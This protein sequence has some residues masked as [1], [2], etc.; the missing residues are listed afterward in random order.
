MFLDYE[1]ILRNKYIYTMRSKDTKIYYLMQ[2]INEQKGLI[3][4][5]SKIIIKIV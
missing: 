3:K 1:L 4:H 5:S 2:Y